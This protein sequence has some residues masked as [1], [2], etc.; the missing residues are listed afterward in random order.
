MADNPYAPPTVVLEPEPERPEI[1]V[2]GR[3][4][5]LRNGAV[6]PSRCVVTNKPTQSAADRF[7]RV[8]EWA[9]SFRPVLRRGRCRVSYCVHRDQRLTHYRNRFLFGFTLLLIAWLALGNFVWWF[10]L[11]IPVNMFGTPVDPLRVRSM[12]NGYFWIEG[13]SE[14]YLRDCAQQFGG[15]SEP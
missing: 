9:P 3:Y 13:C 11:L 5:I 2:D 7:W 10:S 4:L 8:F 14:D 12:K 6:L 1:T 15:Q